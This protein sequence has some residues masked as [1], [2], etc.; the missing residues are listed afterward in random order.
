MPRLRPL[1]VALLL[2]ACATAPPRQAA[3]PWSSPTLDLC[4]GVAVSNAPATDGYRRILAYTPYTAIRNVVLARAPTA[5]CMS[6]AFGPRQGGAGAFHDGVDLYTGSPRFVAA[7]GDGRIVEAGTRR[8]YG[9]TV[10]IAHGRGV[11]TLYAHLSDLAPGVSEGAPIR[12]GAP[13]GRTG[14]S[15]NATAVHLHYEIRI[16]GRPVDPLRAGD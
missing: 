3:E 11:S 8:G 5:G 12:A 9:L 14:R 13:V 7:G 4:S 2:G 6:S 16:D 10:E 15:G 1:L